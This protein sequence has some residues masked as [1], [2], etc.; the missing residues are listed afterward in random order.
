[1][2]AGIQE[3]E[4]HKD[5]AFTWRS[6]TYAWAVVALLIVAF[7]FA[8]IDRMILTLLVGPLK[9]DFDLSD[10]Q[11]SLLHGLA[12]TLLYVI[13][14]IPM[15]W[16]TD[17][18]SRR[19]IAGAS[20]A[21]W[22]LM[23]ALCGL[24]GNFVQLFLARMGVGIGE[25]GISPAANS[26]IPDY[27]PQSRVSLPLTLYSIG[28]SA[29]SGLALIFGGSIVDYVSHL[30]WISIPLIGDIRGWQASFLIVGCRVCS[31]PRPSCSSRSRLAKAGNLR[32]R[33]QPF[34]SPRRCAC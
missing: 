33:R 17:R 15:G 34:R 31:S 32:T 14:G 30:G 29:G 13:V 5:S 22:S 6:E 9:A 23:T 26:L 16:L 19:F 10:T 4:K 18:Y 3:I 20:V 11:V 28:G 2:D 21:S 8:M 24:S 27:F 1:M 7:T 12:F 25:A